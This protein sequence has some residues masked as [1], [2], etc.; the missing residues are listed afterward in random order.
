M[1]KNNIQL[2]WRYGFALSLVVAGLLL[3]YLNIGTEFLGFASVGTWMI[4][5]GFVMM[6]VVTLQTITKKKRV[7]D[8]RMEFVAA[9]AGRVTFIAIIL[10]AFIVMI[11]DGI[12][13]ISIAYSYF[14]SYFICGILLVY[15]VS[16]RIL[17]RL[18]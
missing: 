15:L 3:A 8:E 12:R 10:T 17:L 18:S 13:P 5:V 11:L 2:T 1:A 9:K 6:A 14:M 7:V 16:Y 4:Y